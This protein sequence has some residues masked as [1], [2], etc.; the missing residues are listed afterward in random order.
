MRG[1]RHDGEQRRTVRLLHELALLCERHEDLLRRRLWHCALEV[2]GDVDRAVAEIR[3]IVEDAKNEAIVSSYSTEFEI[4][5][6]YVGRI[7]GAGGASVNKLRDTLA[8]QAIR[9]EDK[10]GVLSLRECVLCVS[11]AGMAVLKCCSG[12]PRGGGR[13]GR[14]AV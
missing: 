1:C 12:Y 13:G 3:K 8:D 4:E 14:V 10:L 11:T 6:E 7:V 2:R 9:E 5:R